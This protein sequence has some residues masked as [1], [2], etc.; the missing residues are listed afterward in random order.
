MFGV[1]VFTRGWIRVAALSII[2]LVV[3]PAVLLLLPVWLMGVLVYRQMR[4]KRAL[5]HRTL[6]AMTV[7]PPL[8]YLLCLAV[9]LPPL[10]LDITHHMLGSAVVNGLLRFSNEFLW[11][12][13]IGVLFAMHLIGLVGL[14][15]RRQRKTSDVATTI[16][17]FG[18]LIRWGAGA[19]FSIYLVHYPSLQLVDTILPETM[20]PHLRDVSLLGTVLLICFFFAQLFERPIGRLRTFILGLR[21]F[22]AIKRP[23]QAQ[24]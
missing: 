11:N 13:M 10:L 22:V 9:N 8:A 2:F 23:Q 4:T 5:Q 20:P 15:Q 16:H 14:M 12:W 24:D 19:S 6:L 7:L 3:G 17:P 1:A 18:S 21:R